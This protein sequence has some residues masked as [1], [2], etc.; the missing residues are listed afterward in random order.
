[1]LRECFRLWTTSMCI[2]VPPF[3][4]LGHDY[5]VSVF[6]SFRS[7]PFLHFTLEQ[8]LQRNLILSGLIEEKIVLPRLSGEI[9]IQICVECNLCFI[10]NS[11]A[12]RS[13]VKYLVFREKRAMIYNRNEYVCFISF[14][15]KFVLAAIVWEKHIAQS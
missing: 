8:Q 7:D 10:W 1:M 14:F 9:K 15:F 4:Y 5:Y 11:I 3:H 2:V 12:E 6:A 13:N